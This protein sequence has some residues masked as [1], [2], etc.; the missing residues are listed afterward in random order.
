MR[1]AQGVRFTARLDWYP[2]FT[3]YYQTVAEYLRPQL[4]KIGIDVQLRPSP[5]FSTWAQRI[6]NWD[7]DIDISSAYNYGDPVIGVHRTYLSTNI[8]KGVP[9]SN[10]QGYS[11][12]RVDNMLNLA[13]TE[14][15][16]VKRKAMYFEFQRIVNEEVPLAILFEVP[17][18]SFADKNLKNIPLGIWGGLMPYDEVYWANAPK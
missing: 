16:P 7:F 18:V 14:L 6:S 3:D 13:A 8:R 15:D 5:D 1:N 11:N 2:G 10:T 4:K 9:Y 17:V 12:N